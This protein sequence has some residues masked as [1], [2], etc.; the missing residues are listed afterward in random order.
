MFPYFFSI[1]KFDNF[2]GTEGVFACLFVD[3]FLWKLLRDLPH[4][5][6]VKKY[7]SWRIL[8]SV[9][10]AGTMQNIVLICC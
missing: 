8:G 5:R 3:E 2:G 1:P 7:S 9:D 10:Y 6:M 4:F